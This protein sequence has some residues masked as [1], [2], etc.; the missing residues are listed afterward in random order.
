MFT[1]NL[2]S[3]QSMLGCGWIMSLTWGKVPPPRPAALHHW[4]W[5]SCRSPVWKHEERLW[6][7]HLRVSLR[8]LHS[9]LI[10]SSL[11]LIWLFVSSSS[12]WESYAACQKR[13]C[14]SKWT[15]D[16]VIPDL[17][18]LFWFQPDPRC[19]LSFPAR[20][21]TRGSLSEMCVCVCVWSD[22]RRD[23]AL[24]NSSW[25]ESISWRDGANA[26][27]TSHNKLKWESRRRHRAILTA[28]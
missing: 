25:T 16:L 10:I 1:T 11:L 15:H 7:T 27:K 20:R 12:H 19:S 6:D 21:S 24:Q 14:K 5:N 4:C 13:L 23:V 28:F 26:S 22:C 18:K 2:C 8:T 9:P 17:N 3:V